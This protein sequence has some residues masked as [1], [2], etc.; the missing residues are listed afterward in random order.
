MSS[1]KVYTRPDGNIEF[2]IT[3][4]QQKVICNHFGKDSNDLCDYEIAEL[5]DQLIDEADD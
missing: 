1:D 2:I 3:P 4:D 5:L